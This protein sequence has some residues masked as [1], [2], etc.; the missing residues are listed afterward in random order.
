[1]R[2]ARLIL[3]PGDLGLY[4]VTVFWRFVIGAVCMLGWALAT[5]RAVR[6]GWPDHLRFALLGACL[7]SVNYY[8]FYHGGK[9]LISG[10]LAVIFLLASV[11]NLLMGAA[12]YR[13]RI[14]GRLA[15][16]ALIGCAGIALMF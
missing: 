5:R 9:Y 6:F 11:F 16:A 13:D 7:F 12:L 8:F 2:V 3:T 1:M 10:L 14:D 15:L 4:A